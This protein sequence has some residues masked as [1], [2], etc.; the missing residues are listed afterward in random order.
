MGEGEEGLGW[1]TAGCY[2]T[3]L[4]AD[5][6][7][8]LLPFQAQEVL[9]GLDDATFGCDG[10][11]RVDVVSSHHADCD[12]STLAFSDS[13]RDLEEIREVG[14]VIEARRILG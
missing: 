14:G 9:P 3:F 7:V 13:F 6:S 8:E 12:A 1:Q 2:L 11:G 10:P 4:V 5:P